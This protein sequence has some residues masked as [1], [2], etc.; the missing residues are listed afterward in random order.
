MPPAS[1]FRHSATQSGTRA[2]RYWTEFPSSDSRHIPALTFFSLRYRND[3]MPTVR[4]SSV[5]KTTRR[6]KKNYPARLQSWRC[7]AIHPASSSCWYM[8][9]PYCLTCFMD[10]DRSL[11]NAG[12]PEAGKK[13]VRYWHFSRQSVRHRYSGIRV[14]PVTLV[15]DQFGIAPSYASF[16]VKDIPVVGKISS[17]IPFWCIQRLYKASSAC[18]K[19]NMEVMRSTMDLE[20]ALPN[21]EEVR[22]TDNDLLMYSKKDKNSKFQFLFVQTSCP[23]L[24][25]S[26]CPISENSNQF[27]VFIY[28]PLSHPVNP[29]IRWVFS[30]HPANF[31]LLQPCFH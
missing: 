24:N 2:F 27:I 3:Q 17:F 25:I 14:S 13:L 20:A 5:K 15:T 7:R 21:L 6:W 12:I 28:N 18:Q 1:A 11:V 19:Q 9:D 26:A 10:T 23:Y 16:T 30:F 8:S 22:L 29:Y 31:K 4:R